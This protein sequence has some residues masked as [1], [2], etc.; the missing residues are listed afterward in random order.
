MMH[1]RRGLI[2]GFS[3]LSIF[4]RPPASW[5]S[6]AVEDDF[7]ALEILCEG[8]MWPRHG[9]WQKEIGDIGRDG[10]D[11]YLHSPT[12]D[13]NPASINPG[14]REETLRQLKETADMAAAIGA[15]YITTHPGI[16]H[17]PIPRIWDMC[18]E[19]ALQTLAEAS[20]YA[21][22][23][24]VVLSIENM[25]NK[26][27]FLCTN[28]GELDMFRKRCSSGVTIDVGHAVTCPDPLSFM[29]LQHISYLHVNDNK[30]D[31]DT[32]LCPGD[33]ILDLGMLKLHDHMIIELNDYN[34]VLRAR[35]V[36]LRSL[37]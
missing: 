37:Q 28:A 32:H 33:G 16:I 27:T 25:P 6:I 14:I 4:M 3:T 24:G 1:D 22:S 13:L 29:K 31:K 9:L 36:I 30:G 17:K 8:P 15:R 12:V 21:K 26:P 2:L 18:L 34:N 20:D 7:N 10:I 23:R 19:Y 5:A 11:V 35:D